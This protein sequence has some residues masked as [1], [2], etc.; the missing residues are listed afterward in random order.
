V[1]GSIPCG[2]SWHTLSPF[3]DCN[4]FLYGGY[5]QNN[6]ALSENLSIFCFRDVSSFL[7]FYVSGDCWLYNVKSNTWME[8][9][10]RGQKRLWHTACASPNGD[11]I[12]FGGCKNN[13]LDHDLEVVSA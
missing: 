5:S 6:S 4:L 2:R 13:I 9:P 12:I 3:D 1:T 11:I 8:M 10:D 7:S